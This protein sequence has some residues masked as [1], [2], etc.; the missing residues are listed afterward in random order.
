MTL[1]Q[2][3][4]NNDT[5]FLALSGYTQTEFAALVPEFAHAFAVRMQT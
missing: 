2:K 4:L 1:Y 5:M 3:Y